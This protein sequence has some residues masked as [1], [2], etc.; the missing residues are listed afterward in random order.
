ML[1]I[2]FFYRDLG[3]V[4]VPK[5]LLAR[6]EGVVNFLAPLANLKSFQKKSPCVFA[7]ALVWLS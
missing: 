2:D 4:S 5:L 1:G 6:K 7:G 3:G